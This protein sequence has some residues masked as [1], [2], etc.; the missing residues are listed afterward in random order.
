MGSGE[1]QIPRRRAVSHL[2]GAL[3]PAA[4]PRGSSRIW[5]LREARALL[6]FMGLIADDGERDGDQQPEE[7]ANG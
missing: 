6:A 5:S 3:L 4:D 7:R 1:G 2:P